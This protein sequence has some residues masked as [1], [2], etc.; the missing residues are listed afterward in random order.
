LQLT[1]IQNQYYK[2]NSFNS[3]KNLKPKHILYCFLIFSAFSSFL[4]VSCN[5][6]KSEV[7]TDLKEQDFITKEIQA[8]YL[9]IKPSSKRTLW[10]TG[11]N[12]FL[13]KRGVNWF[14]LWSGR[15]EVVVGCL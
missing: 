4:F 7:P 3:M 6:Q 13:A 8:E 1:L 12:G 2:S 15:Q 10:W 11:S 9:Q 5:K 14:L